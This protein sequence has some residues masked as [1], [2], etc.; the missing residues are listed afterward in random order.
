MPNISRR[1]TSFR[2]ELSVGAA[3]VVTTIVLF[4]LLLADYCGT[5]MSPLVISAMSFAASVWT[6]AGR[7]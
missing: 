1:G 5:V 2:A 7:L 3:G 6:F 4:Y